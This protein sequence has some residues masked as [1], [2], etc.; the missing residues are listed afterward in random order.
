M[1]LEPFK[2]RSF[3]GMAKNCIFFLLLILKRRPAWRSITPA[4]LFEQFIVLF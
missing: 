2:K 4:A 3:S 1:L